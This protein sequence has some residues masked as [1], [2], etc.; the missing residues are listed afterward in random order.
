MKTV[1]IGNFKLGIDMRGD[2]TDLPRGAVR[3]AIN[4]NITATGGISRREGTMLLAGFEGA[5]S[6]WSPASGAYG[7][8]AHYDALRLLTLRAD[9]PAVR[10]IASGLRWSQRMT[11]CEHGDVVIFSNGTE[12]GLADPKGETRMLGVSDPAGAP[13]VS[14]VPG[15]LQV[16]R[17]GA[18]YSFI[19]ARGEES[20]LSP[21][22]FISLEA[23]GGVGF[24]L[25]LPPDDVSTIRLYTTPANG[26][27]LY[28]MADVPAGVLQAA[29][30]DDKPGKAATT[31][32]MQRMTGGAIVRMFNSRLLVA[33]GD[34]LYFSEPFN[35]GLTSARH[36][37]VRFQH[38]ITMLEPVEGGVYVGTSAAVYFLAGDGPENF[39]QGVASLNAPALGASSMIA[40][41]S[42]PEDMER[43]G[44]AP[45][46]LWLGR[47]GYSVG[48]ATGVV[49]DVQNERIDLPEYDAGSMVTYTKNGLVQV[50]SVV[51]SEQSNGAGSAIDFPI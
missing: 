32:F 16:G 41:A 20:G 9:M 44:D 35:P 42:L 25:P 34:T 46:A 3:D 18:A 5:H 23:P 31:Q 45:C 26:E 17:Y 29:A 51:Q 11:Y 13:T 27:L 8:F 21:A 14:V 36:N 40:A 4:I 28:Q 37:F 6:L 38:D 50:V 15:G 30:T 19:N 1:N 22:S 24:T 12:L 2:E 47:L 49:H 10:T 48:T 43:Q 7:L 39:E 33:R